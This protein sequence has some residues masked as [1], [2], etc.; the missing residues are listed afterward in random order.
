MGNAINKMYDKLI[1]LNGSEGK[2]DNLEAIF[3]IDECSDSNEN[4]YDLKTIITKNEIKQGSLIEIYNN[5]YLVIDIEDKFKKTL[6]T[7][8]TI[9]KVSKCWYCEDGTDVTPTSNK[10]IEFYGI[11]EMKK[12]TI[13]NANGVLSI[14]EDKYILMCRFI[15]EIDLNYTV[16]YK[17]YKYKVQSI[18]NT[19]EGIKEIIMKLDGSYNSDE[20]YVYSISINNDN[21]M[22]I[23]VGEMLPI[24]CT[25]KKNTQIDDNPTI[26]YSTDNNSISISSDGIV[27]GKEEGTSIITATY[28]DVSATITVNIA[29]ADEYAIQCSDISGDN[30]S[31]VQLNPICTINGVQVI[32]PT[33]TYTVLDSSI[34]ICSDKGVVTGV[35]VGETTIL[36]EWQGISKTINVII[37]EVILN[38]IIEGK[39]QFKHLTQ[40]VYTLNPTNNNCVWSLDQDSI[41]LEIARIDNQDSTSCT[42]YGYQTS[43]SEF[44]TLY[45]K[46]GDNVLAEKTITIKKNL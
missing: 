37:N 12:D 40:S 6:Y 41:D 30:G 9:R 42:V 1:K 3:L 43:S 39:D 25:C 4:N 16:M 23:K 26:R 31:T 28:Q 13:D 33:I 34:A 17:N 18:N 24:T 2:I 29:K 21:P 36:L 20:K 38:Y 14:V 11:I 5:Y 46:D 7:K 22:T 45:A 8:A 35:G 27:T 44:F 32:E 15:E 10:S 19:K